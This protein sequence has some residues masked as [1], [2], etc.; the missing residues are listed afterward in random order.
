MPRDGLFEHPK[1]FPHS[2]PVLQRF[3]CRLVRG[4]SAATSCSL[5]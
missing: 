4:I 3:R 5:L 2:P 1:Y